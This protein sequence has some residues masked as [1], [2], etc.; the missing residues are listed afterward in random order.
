MKDK[1]DLVTR[2]IIKNMRF[3]KELFNPAKKCERL[4]HTPNEHK[5]RIRKNSK[6]W[7]MTVTDFSA[8]IEI[9]DR[10]NKHLSEPFK[11]EEIDSY[12]SCSMPS[13]MWNKMREK[14]Y[15][16]MD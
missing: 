1:G 13:E 14:G 3:V 2:E 7:R 12:N 9:C 10:C 15:L 16:I 6:D 11:L 4:G 5:I 8:R